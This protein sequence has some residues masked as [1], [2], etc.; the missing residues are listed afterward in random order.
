MTP[1]LSRATWHGTPAWQLEDEAL[2]VIVVPQ[3]G[4]KIVSLLDRRAGYEWLV[5][6][7]HANP[8]RL[9]PPGTSYNDEQ[10]GG[11]DEMLPTIL[12]GPYPVPGPYAG[13]ALPDHGEL[14]TMAWADAGTG[15]GAIR[16][17]ADGV[18][19]PYR[20][21]RTLALTPATG[22]PGLRLDY[23]LQ[24]TGAAPLAYLWAAHPQFACEAGARIVLPPDVAE[25]INVL[26]E[27]WGP[28][29]GGPGTR[30]AWPEQPGAGRQDLVA[31]VARAGGRKF[32]LPPEAPIAWAG[33][34]QPG[35]GCWLR[36]KWDPVCQPYCGVWIDE[37]Y[38]NKIPAVAIEPTTG[39]YDDLAVACS[40]GR[41]AI[42]PPGST[43]RWW[44]E[45]SFGRL[46]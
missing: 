23:A 7:A 12:A 5:Q 13:I 22:G 6:P 24:N 40:N 44:L 14:W 31:G 11:W 8:F 29:W 26:P 3:A 21:E 2:R 4:G 27:S 38:L 25:V 43:A 46:P 15:H 36:L 9:L 1:S 17:A 35:A 10:V 37:G 45:I 33:L 18:A 42:L 41:V 20:I 30:N 28:A 34:E 32:Y 19:L 16:L 39:Y